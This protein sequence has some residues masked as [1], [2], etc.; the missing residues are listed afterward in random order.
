MD[1]TGFHSK[2][3][4]LEEGFGGTEPLIANGDDLTIGKFI[5][6]LEGGRGSSGGH[7]LFEVKGNIAELLLDVTDNFTLS[8]GGE[9]VTALSKDLHEVVG[10][11]TASQVQTE[12]GM[13][14]S[15]T[16]IDGDIVGDTITRVHDHTD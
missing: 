3:G 4:R 1:T 11:L 10:E 9:R 13:G 7:L 6:L 16:F 5:G 12:D 8:G 15:I 2:E 14:K